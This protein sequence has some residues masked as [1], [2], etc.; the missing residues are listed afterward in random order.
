MSKPSKQLI[1][2]NLT[3]TGR[4]HFSQVRFTDLLLF[5][6]FEGQSD[7][8]TL[9]SLEIDVCN[10]PC[11]RKVEDALGR[12]LGK[13]SSSSTAT[14]YMPLKDTECG[15]R[16]RL[17]TTLFNTCWCLMFWP[18]HTNTNRGAAPKNLPGPLH[19]CRDSR[20]ESDSSHSNPNTHQK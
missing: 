14:A 20:R 15:L 19:E 16:S 13:R 6:C 11:S 7:P 8:E 3:A 2:Q 1:S 9:F 17:A 18:H 5:S 4:T 10:I 12:R